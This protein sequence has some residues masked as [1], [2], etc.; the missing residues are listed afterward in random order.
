MYMISLKLHLHYTL[1]LLIPFKIDFILIDI[2]LFTLHFAT[3]NT[4]G[5]S[6]KSSQSNLFTLHFATINTQLVEISMQMKE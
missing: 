4:M 1:L 5:D 3:I 6:I 2:V